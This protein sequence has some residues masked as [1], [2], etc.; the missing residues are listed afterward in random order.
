M[1]NAFSSA[2]SGLKTSSQRLQNSANNVSNVQTPGFK[3]SRVVQT[4]VQ[5]GG[6][7][8]AG[9][10]RS[11][12]QGS[13]ISTGNPLDLAING[14][15]FFQV[16]LPG[17]GSGFTRAGS[18]NVN[19]SGQLVDANGNPLS[20]AIT[21]PGNSEGI[22]VAPDGT[23]SALVGGTQQTLGQIQTI[24]FNNPAGLNT[25]GSN[26]FGASGESG[27]P[28][29]GSPGTGGLGQIIPGALETSNVDIAAEAVD[30]ILSKNAFTANANVIRVAD[31][32]TGTLLDI[33]A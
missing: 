25:L 8:L 30:Q 12:N 32:M 3:A 21:I 2:L 18:F 29:P 26:V 15:G 33:K 17:G 31:E 19:D 4:D 11:V 20:P 28:I 13:I 10:Q 6:A 5:A 23:V 24:S 22:S 27:Q 1:I 7:T 9:T 16:T 14:G